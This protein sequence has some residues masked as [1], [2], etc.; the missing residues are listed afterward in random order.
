MGM[1]TAVL[2]IMALLVVRLGG[3]DS[4]SAWEDGKVIHVG[5]RVLCQDCTKGYDE[6]VQ[7][8]RPIKGAKVSLTCMDQRHRVIFYGSDDTDGA[9]QFYMIVN[10]YINGKQLNEKLCSVRLV[11][12]PDPT[13]D[14][15]T[16]FA[17]GCRGVELSRPS[18]VYRE[19]IKYTVGPLYYTSPMC[20]KPEIE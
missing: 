1:A 18:S 8:G 5:G 10:K 17:G 7:G 14:V 15:A 9:G 3:A 19:V 20:E 13:C 16:D 12:S 11:S 6:W 4:V 2:V